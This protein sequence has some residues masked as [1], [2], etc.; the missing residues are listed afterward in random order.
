MRVGVPIAIHRHLGLALCQSL[1]E[2][3]ISIASHRLSS[4]SVKT[5]YNGVIHWRPL[6]LIF[7]RE[8]KNGI[9]QSQI[10]FFVKATLSLVVLSSLLNKVGS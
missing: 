8:P 4:A 1:S 2:Y 3:A 10:Y 7:R 9:K 5:K 6:L